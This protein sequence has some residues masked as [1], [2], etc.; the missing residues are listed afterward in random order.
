MKT[1]HRLL[2]L[3]I[4]AIIFCY[5]YFVVNKKQENVNWQ[6][7]IEDQIGAQSVLNVGKNLTFDEKFIY[8]S[9]GKDTIYALNQKNGHI[10]WLSKLYD[11][12]PFQITQ[13]SDSLYVASFDS[14]IY[15]LDKSNGYIVWSFAIHNQF[16]PDT[17]VIF[18][19]NDQYVFFADRS[20][21]LYALDKN[22]GHEVWKKEFQTIDN[23]K[24]FK[25]GSIHF[26]FLQQNGNQ[27]IVDHFPSETIFVIDKNSGEIISKKKSSLNIDLKQSQQ[28]L[29]FDQY[30]LIIKQNVI[31]QPIF[32]L[33]DKEENSLWSYQ[34]RQK[35]NLKEVYQDKNRMYWLDINNQ[36]LSSIAIKS[37]APKDQD[38]RKVNFKIE[39]NFSTHEPC[40]KNPNPQIGYEIK[41]INWQSIIK[42]KINYYKYLL[43]NINQLIQFNI[44]VEEKSNY[45]EFNILHQDNFY[46][47]KFTQ[48]NISGE[49]WNKST[50]EKIK[51]N[52][53]YY[54][55]NT[56][57][58]RAK[59]DP[60]QWQY[61]IKIGT[62]FWRKKI[63]GTTQ[64]NGKK[65][66]NLSIKN[67]GFALDDSAFSPLGLQDGFIESSR[68][69]NPL[70]KLGYAL[71]KTP[72][73]DPGNYRY[74]PFDE[75]LE[76]NRN[77]ASMNIF[78]YGSD[79]WA[80]SIWQNLDS[81]KQFEMDVNGNYQGD[82]ITEEAGKREYRI[83]MSIFAFYPPHASREAFAK[84]AN[85]EVLKQYLD[86]VIS[87]YAASIDIWELANEAV[88]IL[89]W[90]NFISDYLFTHDP[91]K[92]PITTSLEEPELNNS[93]LLSIHYVA[94]TPVNNKDL[95]DKIISFNSSYS[96]D[97]AKIISEFGFKDANHF[98]NSADW[99]RKFAWIFTFQK[100]GI[101]FWNTG[102]CFFENKETENSNIYIGPEERRYLKTLNNFLPSLDIAVINKFYLENKARLAVYELR[103]ENYYLF[104]LLNLDSVDQKQKLAI[105]VK[106]N[107]L[108]TIVDPKTGRVLQEITIDK[109]QR[110]LLLPAFKDDLAIKISYY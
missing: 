104:Y 84:K 12:S 48:V 40:K 8:F 90:Q 45:L 89:E 54:D 11:H 2:L 96:Q 16:W 91:Y 32:N 1:K 67:N 95:V 7:F 63:V 107:G 68:D 37:I 46:K 38:F 30:N 79:N 39:E 22:T 108:M 41:N 44:N 71:Q 75:Y 66:S 6:F 17:E 20:G 94:K 61:V 92:H 99:M 93:D 78:R 53:F 13:D 31:N 59:L 55:K 72:P 56:W 64:I 103:D 62:L 81:P 74:L 101:I 26:G 10:N 73:T 47:N 76:I 65:Q 100:T 80:P 35:V 102:L 69:G 88:P 106:R 5:L 58:L 4:I 83:M 52:G 77:E 43:G 33:L 97:K 9:D 42:E 49:L 105:E 14:H 86:Y 70:N 60:G 110:E 36:I 109:G 25:E 85:R 18:D 27:L 29:I 87:R 23:T 19:D 51:V 82:Y 3:L 50:E 34:T 98:A 57:K 21:F 15:K 24:V 28:L